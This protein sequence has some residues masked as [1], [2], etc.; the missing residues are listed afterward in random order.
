MTT[1]WHQAYMFID[2]YTP[3]RQ[4]QVDCLASSVLYF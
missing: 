2:S 4:S 3:T 1:H